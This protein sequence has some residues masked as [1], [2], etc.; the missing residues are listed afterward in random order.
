MD[1]PGLREQN[2]QRTR[3]AIEEAAARLFGERGFEHTTVRDIAAAAGVGERTFF[4]Y[5]PSKESLIVGQ[6]RDL[7]PRLA[8]LL[9]ERPA[10]E[11]PYRAMCNAVLTLAAEYEVPPA[12]FMTGSPKDLTPTSSRTDRLLLRDLEHAVTA[13]IEERLGAGPD[14]PELRLRAAVKARAG[15]AALRGLLA[16]QTPNTLTT[17]LTMKQL[18]ALVQD[19]FAALN[20]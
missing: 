19:A 13:A 16:V 6:V 9:R 12:I 7:I 14:S 3:R 5:F 4:R 15:V 20:D 2:K 18:T 1:S 8:L 10:A 11:A 17:G